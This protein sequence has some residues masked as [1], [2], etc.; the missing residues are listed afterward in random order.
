MTTPDVTR[1]EKREPPYTVDRGFKR[2]GRWLLTHREWHPSSM[3]HVDIGHPE[4][5]VRR[6]DDGVIIDGSFWLIQHGWRDFEAAEAFILAGLEK[7][8]DA[9]R[10]SAAMEWLAD[11][12]PK[13]QGP[14]FGRMK[15]YS[16]DRAAS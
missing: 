14:R 4:T 11:R 6:I 10:V 2:T 16:D 1:E 12:R 5:G 8:W 7:G 13:S 9:D 15:D 3:D